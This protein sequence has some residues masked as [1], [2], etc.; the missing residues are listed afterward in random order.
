MLAFLKSRTFL[1]LLGLVLLSLLLWFV[2]PY[3]AFAD[4]KPLESTVAR[5]VAILVLVV[6]WA[7][8]LQLKQLKSS[9]ASNK[10]A[11]EVVA[12]ESESAEGAQGAGAGRGNAGDA[13]QLRKRFEDAVEALKKSKRK[14]AANLYELPW[15]VIIGPPG[16]GKTTVLV[17]SGLN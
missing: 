17:N 7:V 1:V 12:Q 11:S 16:S 15:Y 9:R 10:L 13:A 14:G 2:G 5:L 6:I 3:F 4:Y 8:V